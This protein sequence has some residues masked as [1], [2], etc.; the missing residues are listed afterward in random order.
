VSA[1]VVCHG[2]EVMV[3]VRSLAEGR[4]QG[5]GVVCHR[6]EFWVRFVLG[7]GLC[8]WVQYCVSKEGI[9]GAE[10]NPGGALAAGVGCL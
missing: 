3:P 7:G 9:S 4:V 10:W 1:G 2:A 6:K 8:G 5:F